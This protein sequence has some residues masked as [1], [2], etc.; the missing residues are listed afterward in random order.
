MFAS[1]ALRADPEVV[2]AA[3]SKHG[4]HYSMQVTN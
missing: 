2:M 1:L 4:R 3:V